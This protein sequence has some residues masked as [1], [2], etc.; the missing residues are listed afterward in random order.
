MQHP[1]HTAHSLGCHRHRLLLFLLQASPFQRGCGSRGLFPPPLSSTGAAFAVWNPSRYAASSASA[2]TPPHRNFYADLQVQVDATP[3]ELKAAYRRLALK[4]HPDVVVNGAA[5]QAEA[6]F[7][8][9][10]EAYEALADPAKR[11]AHDKSLGIQ[12]RRK[13][14]TASTAAAPPRSASKAEAGRSSSSSSG[15]GGASGVGRETSRHRRRHAAESGFGRGSRDA[16]SSSQQRYRTPFVRGDANRVF[17]DAFD[18]KTLDEI[19]FET[20]RRRRQEQQ[21]QRRSGS[22]LS[23]SPSG[24]APIGGAPKESLGAE[25]LSSTA[26]PLS[27]DE[28]LRRVMEEAAEAFA[29]R[30]QRQY[31]H[32]ILRHIQASV[33]PEMTSPA[34]PPS[35]SLPFYP[36]PGMKLPDGVKA[37]PL[38]QLG[39]V[40]DADSAAAVVGEEAGVGGGVGTASHATKAPAPSYFYGHFYKDGV[41]LPRGA[42][43]KKAS[44]RIQ[45]A[46]HNMGQLYSY[47]RP[48]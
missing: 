14:Q 42:S 8:R 2:M 30:A 16:A 21:E 24:A 1:F 15:S 46:A 31:G 39:R 28:R 12:T 37:P 38:P 5:A 47:Q 11:L 17:A 20:A 29:A 40:L 18:G 3:A 43:L 23:R 6:Q 45:G 22:G 34:P 41:P 13:P 9:V 10:S 44:R 27:R 25:E 36:F 33:R 35:S 48:F 7:R 32:G 19:L 26:E 4:W